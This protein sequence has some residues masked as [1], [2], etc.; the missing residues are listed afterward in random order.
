MTTRGGLMSI[1]R[2]GINRSERGP[3]AKC[4]FEETPDIIVKA[5][6]FGEYDHMEGVSGNIM[7]GQTVPI[8]TGSI[9]VLF[10]EERYIDALATIDDDDEVVGELPPKRSE[11]CK[12]HKLDFSISLDDL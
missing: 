3:L 7:M 8:G 5:A 10:D 11:Y 9:D 12:E 1:D 6:M 4:S 2:H